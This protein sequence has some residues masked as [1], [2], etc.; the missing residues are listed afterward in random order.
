MR[1]EVKG[2]CEVKAG[3]LMASSD[4]EVMNPEHHL[5]YLE[6]DDAQLSLELNVETGQGFREA[7]HSK[8]HAAGTI[9]IDAIFAPILK[10][11]FNVEPRR[12]QNFDNLECLD[13][14][15]WTNGT[16]TPTDAIKQASSL[17]IEQFNLLLDTDKSDPAS[18]SRGK[19]APEVYG[20]SLDSLDMSARTYNALDRAGYSR[21]G[22]V[23]ETSRN[24][25]LNIRNFGQKSFTELI[26]KLDELEIEHP[27]TKKRGKGGDKDN[28]SADE[29]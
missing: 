2:K 6:H 26:A 19:I 5:A 27:W 12:Y 17:I 14:E 10:A 24:D 22:E 7:E 8:D 16:I 11:S 21:I 9:S 3:D 13:F 15:V 23:L 18:I 4:F 25:L 1:L 28:D 29:E 20:K